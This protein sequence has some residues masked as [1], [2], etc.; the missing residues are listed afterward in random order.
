MD[1][2]ILKKIKIL[3]FNVTAP[4]PFS[5]SNTTLEL[6]NGQDSPRNT[7]LSSQ[8]AL[9]SS[10]WNTTLLLPTHSRKTIKCSWMVLGPTPAESPKES[11]ISTGALTLCYQWQTYVHQNNPDTFL[12]FSCFEDI[13]NN[14]I[15]LR[16][17]LKIVASSSTVT[18]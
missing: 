7:C 11:T 1:F 14:D 17:L 6:M 12:R 13:Y 16:I 4:A 8:E 10:M 18:F 15:S 2:S 3:L 5:P 9:G